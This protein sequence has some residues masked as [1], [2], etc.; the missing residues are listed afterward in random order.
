MQ[1]RARVQEL[2]SELQ[3]AR[4]ELSALEGL[5]QALTSAQAGNNYGRS[6]G[7]DAEAL[8]AAAVGREHAV[9]DARNRKVLELLHSKVREGDL[10]LSVCRAAALRLSAALHPCVME[11]CYGCL[12][13]DI[14][15]PVNSPDLQTRGW[16]IPSSR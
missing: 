14:Y 5:Q 9:Q 10:L 1:L 11:P 6:T 4:E 15:N 13:Q 8:V 3:G 12:E 7:V 16:N 2:R